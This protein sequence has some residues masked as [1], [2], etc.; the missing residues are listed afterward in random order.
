MQNEHQA[1]AL[2]E[3]QASDSEITLA[4]CSCGFPFGAS[5]R[6]QIPII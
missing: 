3:Q 4:A 2:Q 1:N 5:F 6:G